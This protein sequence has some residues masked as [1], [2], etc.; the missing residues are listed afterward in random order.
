MPTFSTS[1]HRGS[2]PRRA[3]STVYQREE[4]EATSISS[5]RGL[6]KNFKVQ[7]SLKEK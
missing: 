1:L 2:G 4:W 7:H 3:Q 6:A 5:P